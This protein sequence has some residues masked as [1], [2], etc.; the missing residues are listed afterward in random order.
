MVSS[1]PA[2]VSFASPPLVGPASA[3]SL[4]MGQEGASK[5]EMDSDAFYVSAY[6]KELCLSV[7]VYVAEESVVGDL[8]KARACAARTNPIKHCTCAH[9]GR[10][11]AVSDQH[12]ECE[13]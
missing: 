7:S 8:S 10:E 9:F 13:P 12:L 1:S 3:L 2:N 6:G 11:D 5:G 4:S